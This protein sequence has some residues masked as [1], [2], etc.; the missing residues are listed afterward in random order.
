M[1]IAAISSNLCF[2]NSMYRFI[3]PFGRSVTTWFNKWSPPCLFCESGIHRKRNYGFTRSTRPITAH[4]RTAIC[5]SQLEAIIKKP[6]NTRGVG[7]SFW[8]LIRRRTSLSIRIISFSR[9]RRRKQP[10]KKSLTQG[11]TA[12]KRKSMRNAFVPGRRPRKFPAP[13]FNWNHCRTGV[14]RKKL[15]DS[16]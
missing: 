14:T 10:A 11:L 16:D 12:V 7:T 5:K 13:K 8:S 9:G 2:S 4:E 1:F 15:N 6:G 3:P